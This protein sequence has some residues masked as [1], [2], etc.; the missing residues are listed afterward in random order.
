MRSPSDV[1]FLLG[2]GASV[3]AGMPSIV[4]LTRELCRRLPTLSVRTGK[5]HPEFPRLV[6]A[7]AEL[8]PSV[9]ENYER[10]FAWLKLLI[11]V[12]KTPYQPAFLVNIPANLAKVACALSSD[13]GRPICEILHKG[14]KACTPESLKYLER[15]RDF[16]PD[17]GR[18]PVFTLN[19]DLTV[20]DA[21]RNDGIPVTTGFRGDWCPSL[22]QG[23]DTGINLYKMHGSL[24][25]FAKP[26]TFKPWPLI[27]KGPTDIPDCSD[28]LP[29]LV[30][31]PGS[32]LQNDDPFATLY[33]EFHKALNQAKTCVVVGCALADEHIEAPLK[34]AF[35]R[36]KRIVY[37]NPC[38]PAKNPLN[39]SCIQKTAREAFESGEILRHLATQADE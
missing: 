4:N 21:C 14:W 36:G 3:D 18:L 16:I 22:F 39:F 29:D 20:E 32:K 12:Q 2:A 17:S 19:Y 7:L 1:I 23:T 28:E 33:S 35:H 8:E 24:S 34:R 13:I 10:L 27:E 31:G 26:L 25:W 11:K 30:L 9:A 38:P 5:V 6:A 15:L 37:V